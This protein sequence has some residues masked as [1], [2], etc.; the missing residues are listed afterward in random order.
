MAVAGLKHVTEWAE[1][2]DG[3][4]YASNSVVSMAITL[5]PDMLIE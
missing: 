3:L 5:K 4:I 2:D 1:E